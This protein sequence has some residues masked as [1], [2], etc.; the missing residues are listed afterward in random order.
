[1]HRLPLKMGHFTLPMFPGANMPFA[2]ALGKKVMREMTSKVTECGTAAM[3][4]L[5]KATTRVCS[6]RKGTDQHWA[7]PCG[8]DSS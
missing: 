1:M 6:V 2:H 5:F 8:A 7:S 3:E 4:D